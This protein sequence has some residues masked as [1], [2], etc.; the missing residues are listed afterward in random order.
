[1]N[2]HLRRMGK[3]G[4]PARA[5][6]DYAAQMFLQLWVTVFTWILAMGLSQK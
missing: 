3:S 5:E 6:D 1:M 4:V 2:K